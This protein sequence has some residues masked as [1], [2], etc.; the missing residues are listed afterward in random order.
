M[1]HRVYFASKS[2]QIFFHEIVLTSFSKH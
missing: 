2:K 1:K